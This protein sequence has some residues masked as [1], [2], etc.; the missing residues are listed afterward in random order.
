MRWLVSDRVPVLSGGNGME[1][2]EGS[3]GQYD[4]YQWT[5]NVVE[6][7]TGICALDTSGD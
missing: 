7:G 2:P 6:E 5:F 1:L 4:F 3:D